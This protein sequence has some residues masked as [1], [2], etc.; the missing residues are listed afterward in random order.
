MESFL[1]NT[2]K[3]CI[4][5]LSFFYSVSF[6]KLSQ[7]PYL[8]ATEWSKEFSVKQVIFYSLW[9][10]GAYDCFWIVDLCVCVCLCNLKQNKTERWRD[11]GRGRDSK[12]GQEAIYHS[13]QSPHLSFQEQATDLTMGEMWPVKRKHLS[14]LLEVFTM[15]PCWVHHRRYN[16]WCLWQK[17]FALYWIGEM[18]SNL[19][20]ELTMEKET[21]I[22]L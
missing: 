8:M 11:G 20:Q 2:V 15:W 19:N 9:I 14:R 10:S 5:C 1:V 12:E 22:K 17:P 3:H 16:L 18:M 13:W 21:I 7:R 4:V 6:H